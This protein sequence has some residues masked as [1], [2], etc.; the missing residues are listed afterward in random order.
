MF[1][2]SYKPFHAWLTASCLLHQGGVLW[3]STLLLL[4]GPWVGF[5]HVTNRETK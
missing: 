2:V 4:A 3:S 5:L 1:V